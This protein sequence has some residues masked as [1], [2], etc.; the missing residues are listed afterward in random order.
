VRSL[1]PPSSRVLEPGTYQPR[2]NR[3]VATVRL[4]QTGWTVGSDV[5][6]LLCFEHFVTP[7]GAL[8]EVAFGCVTRISVV[9]TGACPDAA[10]RLVGDRPQD[11]IGW[12]QSTPQ[13]EAS[14]PRSVID[15]GRSGIS[16]HA[17]VRPLP[18][19]G[20][21]VTNPEGVQLWAVSGGEWHP[22]VGTRITF[23]ALDDG[24][25]TITVVFY[26]R[27]DEVLAAFE[28]P[29]GR[30]LVSGIRLDT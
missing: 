30:S 3:D 28:V 23:E 6:D 12:I 22:M 16:I 11:L 2:F 10:T 4:D 1:P 14:D 29:F 17:T 26:A 15:L 27:T 7:A 5:E 8:G 24:G 19:E 21:G 13:L 20:C 9:Y 18:P 25:R